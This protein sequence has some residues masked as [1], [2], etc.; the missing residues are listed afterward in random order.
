LLLI[1]VSFSWLLPDGLALVRWRVQCHSPMHTW[2]LHVELPMQDSL[3][4]QS[5]RRIITFFKRFPAFF[6][7]GD[8]GHDL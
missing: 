5:T 6:V 7:V 1:I 8:S 2:R 4:S 3:V